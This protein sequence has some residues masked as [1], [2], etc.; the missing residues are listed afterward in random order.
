MNPIP[1]LVRVAVYGGCALLFV[2]SLKGC[3]DSLVAKG[4]KQG[5]ARERGVWVATLKEPAMR[6]FALAL[7]LLLTAA[8]APAADLVMKNKANGAQL[9]LLDTPCSHGETLA[10]LKEE[11]RPKFKNARILDAKG[12]IQ[13]YGCWIAARRGDGDRGPAGRRGDGVPGVGLQR[14][15]HLSQ[16]QS[17]PGHHGRNRRRGF[18][19]KSLILLGSLLQLVDS[20]TVSAPG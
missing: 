20:Y 9:R 11:W 17:H 18:L 3:H 13:F 19:R 5:E 15:E 4:D 6:A 8:P 12:F 10:V 14:P 1:L 2:G 7:I 16:R